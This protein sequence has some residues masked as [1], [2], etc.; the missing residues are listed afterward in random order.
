MQ[1]K[2]VLKD[3]AK[4]L[5]PHKK[6]IIAATQAALLLEGL[7][8]HVNVG[9]AKGW[10]QTEGGSQGVE[11]GGLLERGVLDIQGFMPYWLDP[12]KVGA[13]SIVRNSCHL[14]GMLLLTGPNMGGEQAGVRTLGA[15]AGCSMQQL[16]NLLDSGCKHLFG[17]G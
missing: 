11:E 8:S 1:A 9:F 14:D 10:C 12:C 4:Q 17:N 7:Q 3:A 6:Y 15:N 13:A 16:L 5:Q 2:A